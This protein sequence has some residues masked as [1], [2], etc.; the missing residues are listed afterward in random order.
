M[1][2]HLQGMRWWD[3]SHTSHWWAHLGTK[4]RNCIGLAGQPSC[5]TNSIHNLVL[6]CVV[7]MEKY[8]CFLGT[9]REKLPLP[10]HAKCK[11]QVSVRGCTKS[12]RWRFQTQDVCYLEHHSTTWPH[13]TCRSLSTRRFRAATTKIRLLASWERQL[14]GSMHQVQRA[15][16]TLAT[17]QTT[18][19]RTPPQQCIICVASCA[20]MDARHSLLTD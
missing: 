16:D 6:S 10:E 19:S 1:G 14:S 13:E 15:L 17:G 8:R 4:Y 9:T 12:A 11:R 20:S 7:G 5:A 3:A 2:S 18:P